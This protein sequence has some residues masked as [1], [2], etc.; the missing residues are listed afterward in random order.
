MGKRAIILIAVLAV[1]VLIF[2]FCGGKPDKNAPVEVKEKPLAVGEH[3]GPFNES[4]NNLLSS[5]YS[6]KDAFVASDVSKVN[7]AAAVLVK[8]ADGLQTSEIQGDSTGMIK[9]TA[10]QF[11]QSL[12]SSATT[13]AAAA[14]IEA[15]RHEFET[16]T[17]ALWSLT[18]TVQYTGQKVYYQYCPMAFNNKGAYWLSNTTEIRNPY[19]G[20]KMLKCGETAD[21]LD[22]S[23]R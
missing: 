10:K 16:V 12:S 9:E 23:K 13:L 2:R 22:Y 1:V 19:F 6:L 17:E 7:A 8:S 11:A 18:R 4:F 14:D 21:S 3:S 5:Y 15:K 20:D